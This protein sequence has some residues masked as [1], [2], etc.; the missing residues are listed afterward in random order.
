MKNTI[1]YAVYFLFFLFSQGITAQSKKA[2]FEMKIYF[3]D[4]KGNKDSVTVGYDKTASYNI[5]KTF[6]EDEITVPFDSVF[7]VRV[8]KFGSYWDSPI[9][10]KRRI[11]RVESE[12]IPLYKLSIA[13]N[14][15]YPPVK[16]RHKENLANENFPFMHRAILA[17]NDYI[18]LVENGW[19]NAYDWVCFA[20]QNEISMD[21]ITVATLKPWYTRNYMVNG[22]AGLQKIKNLEF[23]QFLNG[24]SCSEILPTEE[25]FQLQTLKVFPNPASEYLQISI[26]EEIQSKDIELYITDINGKILQKKKALNLNNEKIEVA[27]LPQGMYFLQITNTKK[28]IATTKFIKIE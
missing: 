22:K 23:I 17:K 19:Y 12:V 21:M 24:P 8:L 9:A 3:E 7:E 4:A 13:I 15:K 28:V 20:G 18:H 25:I 16:I 2:T 26:N 10:G 6:N 1:E 11:A 14:S 27:D 5:D